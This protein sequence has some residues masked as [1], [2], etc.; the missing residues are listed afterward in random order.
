MVS[1]KACP[2]W[3]HRPF[4][5]RYNPFNGL[6]ILIVIADGQL[7]IVYTAASPQIQITPQ[8]DPV[9]SH[10]AKSHAGDADAEMGGPVASKSGQS[11]PQASRHVSASGA[12]DTTI[13]PPAELSPP[14]SPKQQ[15]RSSSSPLPSRNPNN[16]ALDVQQTFKNSLGTHMD[17]Q[18]SPVMNETLS[19][20]D[21]HITD[22]STPRHSLAPPDSKVANDSGSE[23]SSNLGHRMSYIN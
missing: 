3:H 14:S 11:T 2:D 17:G 4:P 1:R 22:L 19:V 23:Y 9:L 8:T 20:I 10:E 21:E 16:M 13:T 6:D 15:Q 12:P 5:W 7:R 18:D